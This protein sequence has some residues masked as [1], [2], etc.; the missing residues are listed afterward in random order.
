MPVTYPCKCRHSSVYKMNI[1]KYA[2]FKY[3]VKRLDDIIS[4]SRKNLGVICRSHILQRSNITK[5]FSSFITPD[6]QSLES[7][8][9]S[10]KGSLT[11]F[12]LQQAR[13]TFL[14]Y[15][16]KKCSVLDTSAISHQSHSLLKFTSQCLRWLPVVSFL[17]GQ[18]C[19]LW[20]LWYD[21]MSKQSTPG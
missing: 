3:K 13:D 2:R 1:T 5:D 7:V 4:E 14:L 20:F 11:I 17:T 6:R 19:L 9:L 18:Y 21:L 15:Q 16:R 10:T 8:Y 12:Y